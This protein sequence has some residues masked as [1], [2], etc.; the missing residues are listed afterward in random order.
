MRFGLTA[1]DLNA[2]RQV[3]AN[4]DKAEQVIIFGSRAMGNY[5]PGSDIDLAI[6]G[7]SLTLND[8]LKLSI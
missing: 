1:R 3:F 2:I 8:I 4:C 5:K 6:K 7:D